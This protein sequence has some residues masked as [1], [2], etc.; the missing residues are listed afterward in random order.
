MTKPNVLF[1]FND[2]QRFDTRSTLGNSE[3][4]TPNIDRLARPE[5]AVTVESL[6][7]E[8][9]RWRT[10]FGDDQEIGRQFWSDS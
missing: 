5:H 6:R 2:D 8:L 7:K 1:I 9:E 10:E 4:E 3:I